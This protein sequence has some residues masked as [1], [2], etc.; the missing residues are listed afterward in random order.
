MKYIKIFMA[1]VVIALLTTSCD[2]DLPYPLDDVKN[3]VVID[4][5]RV[6]GTDGI[7]SA[8]TT[9]GDYKVK[10]SIPTQQGDYSSLDHVQLVCVFTGKDGK[11][12]S[13]VVQDNIK[14]F[15]S[16]ITLDLEEVYKLFNLTSPSLGE[17]LYFTTNVVLKD[18][19][20]VEGW[21]EYS[22]F[23]NRAFTGWQVDGR[24]Y[25]YNVRYPVACP[26]V[27]D[28]FVGDLTITDNSVFYEGASYPAVG[29]KISETEVEIQGFFEDTNLRIK[30]DPTVHTV[31][32]PKQVLYETFGSYTNF[33]V[34][35]SGTVD[36]CNGIISFNGTVGVDQG[37]YDNNASWKIKN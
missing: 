21:N 9:E 27:I 20:V 35:A 33:Y 1:T 24:A 3:G 34:M 11:T 10:L 12:T 7:L 31:S 14:E 29:V 23:N 16:T 30:I 18:N 17:T 19:Y 22:G 26:L 6:A 25:S 13:K 8:G 28:D 37:T 2:Q 36:A 32:V 15:P 4:I 5:T